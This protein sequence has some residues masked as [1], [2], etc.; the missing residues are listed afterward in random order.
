MLNAVAM[1][2]V[3]EKRVPKIDIAARSKYTFAGVHSSIRGLKNFAIGV[4][5]YKIFFRDNF[6]NN[7]TTIR[8]VY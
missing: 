1:R 8:I 7:T 6:S 5:I 3:P 2:L 4:Y